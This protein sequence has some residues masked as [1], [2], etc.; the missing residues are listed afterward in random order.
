MRIS[1]GNFIGVDRTVPVSFTDGTFKHQRSVNAV[2][3]ADGNYDK[4]ATKLRCLE[5]GA[6]VAA[7]RAAGVFETPAPTED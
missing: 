4:A 5:V 7:K 6:G 2:I 3:D 1:I